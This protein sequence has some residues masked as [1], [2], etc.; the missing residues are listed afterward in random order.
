MSISRYAL[1]ALLAFSTK[2]ILANHWYYGLTFGMGQNNSTFTWL[3][4]GKTIS[5]VTGGSSIQGFG[6]AGY[7]VVTQDIFL[8]SLQMDAGW[9]N[10]NKKVLSIPEYQTET[11]SLRIKSDF[12]Y[13]ISSRFGI[14]LGDFSHYIIV[15]LRAGHW[16]SILESGG[17]NMKAIRNNVGKELGL[18]IQ[19]S[20]SD[21]VDT[22]MEYKHLF[23]RKDKTVVDTSTLGLDVNQS[24]LQLSLVF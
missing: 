4:D 20:I 6:M 7:Q 11:L 16:S 1:T 18:G 19:C 10:L 15:G 22:R 3:A 2:S 24:S 14:T 5:D 9:D 17:L 13:G 21:A 12:S 23:G 8:V